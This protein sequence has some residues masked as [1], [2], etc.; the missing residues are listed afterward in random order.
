MGHKCSKACQHANDVLAR[1]GHTWPLID[2][3]AAADDRND[4]G[5]ADTYMEVARAAETQGWPR[6][7]AR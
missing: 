2:K 4:Q 1:E 7:K 6:H 5:T 3:A